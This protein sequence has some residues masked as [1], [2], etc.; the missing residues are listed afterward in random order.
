[1][2]AMTGAAGDVDSLAA[3][4]Y[5]LPAALVAQEPPAQRDGGRL[6]AAVRGH[7]IVDFT[8]ISTLLQTGD[9]LVFND[10]RVLPS[11]LYGHKAGSGGAVEVLLE[12]ILNAHECLA[13][14]GASKPLRAD[15]V[16]ETQG[17]RFVVCGREGGFY[18][19][20]AVDENDKPTDIQQRFLQTGLVP[21][22]PYI[23]RAPTAEDEAR[24]QTI[25]A[26]SHGSHG[27][28]AAPTA[29]LHFSEAV[30]AGLQ[31]NRIA[32][33]HITLHV[34]AG[35]FMP[36]R[37][38]I[39]EHVM[40]KEFFEISE[41]SAAMINETQARGGRVIAVGTTVLRALESVAAKHGQVQAAHEETQ[42]F[43]KE[44][45]CFKV[46]DVLLTNFHQ[47][48]SSLLVL[49][50]AFGGAARVM[51]L[52]QHAI[53]NRMRFFSYGDCMLIDRMNQ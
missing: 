2:L 37:N 13:Q 25:F 6:L 42:L 31:K 12:R 18:R 15:A 7:A 40:H 52:Y 32:M 28:V 39:D 22:P 29:G 23:N 46:A 38:S 1:M 14:V 8:E 33:T 45:F 34:G 41:A 9:L 17:G 50:C 35:T 21:L 3:Y 48:R 53:K 10:S 27:S 43:I 51:K 16:V 44:G 19:L 4:D 30:L 49:V 47:P 26:R 20:R 5:E 24:Y 11:R 36:I